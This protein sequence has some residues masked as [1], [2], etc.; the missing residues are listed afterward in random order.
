MVLRA[1]S[2][3]SASSRLSW[4][5]IAVYVDSAANCLAQL[6]CDMTD[7]AAALAEARAGSRP[8]F[9]SRRACVVH[10]SILPNSTQIVVLT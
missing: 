4:Q 10:G 5:L 7:M 3:R 1:V 9:L 2:K 6:G 8:D